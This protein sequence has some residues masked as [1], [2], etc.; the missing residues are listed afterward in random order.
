MQ[1]K[2]CNCPASMPSLTGYILH[3]SWCDTKPE[4]YKK[5]YCDDC[6]HML[7]NINCTNCAEIKRAYLNK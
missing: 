6:G 2:K 7:T 4:D 3:R 1:N 5:D